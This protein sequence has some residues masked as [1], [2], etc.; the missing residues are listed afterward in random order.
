MLV[1][2]L[3]PSARHRFHLLL[4][5]VMGSLGVVSLGALVAEL[6]FYLAPST[7]ATLQIVISVVVALFIAQEALRWLLVDDAKEYIRQRWLENLLAALASLHFI[8][9]DS[10]A[11][12][13]LA[14]LPSLSVEQVT[15]GYLALTQM[16]IIVSLVIKGVRYNSYIADLQL[17]PGVV[18]VISFGLII[19]TGALLLQLPRATT[20][21]LSFLDTLFTSTSAVCVTGLVVVN[22]AT[23]YTT[24]GKAVIIILIQIGGLGVMTIT[25]SFALFFAGGI[26]VRERVMMSSLLNPESI[27]EVSAILVRIAAVTFL[28]EGI[29]ALYLYLANGGSLTSPEPIRFYY[30]LF[31]SVSA[32]CNAGFS[33]YPDGLYEETVRN[34]WWY[35]SGIMAL[36]TLGGLGFG[37]IS[38]ILSLRRKDLRRHLV[39][40]KLTT[41][42]KLVL[43]TSLLLIVAGT[44]AI[45][46]SQAASG[47]FAHLPWYEQVWQSLFLSVS[48]RTAGFNTLPMTVVNSPTA[49][50]MVFLMWIGAS[51]GSTGGGIKTTVIAVAVIVV[52]NIVRGKERVEIFRR[53]IDSDSVRKAFATVLVSV[54]VL[55]IISI[56]LIALE[57]AISPI[58]LV[59]EATSALSTVGLS[60]DITPLLSQPSKW[61]LIATMF[62]GRVGILTLLFALVRPVNEAKY[63]YPEESINIS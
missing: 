25:T 26:S 14:L 48:A 28:V 33:L 56:T 22:T 9:P 42:T 54:F 63:K 16:L 47:A 32:F 59:F 50:V 51:P 34:N 46:A 44:L 15:T 5:W 30:A 24:F 61:I 7:V 12:V 11:S 40:T 27:G 38:N 3:T 37:V 31:H 10:L 39:A 18:F 62:I 41:S 55:G 29:G 35:H 8:S 36:I 49:L 52:A 1:N 60:I 17:H 4:D 43:V 2:Y 23:A 21:P 13:V 53:Q 20:Q 58:S 57:P 45:T 19:L 6:G